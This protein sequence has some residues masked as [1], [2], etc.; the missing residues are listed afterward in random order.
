[1]ATRSSLKHY[2]VPAKPLRRLDAA[3]TTAVVVV[4]L[5]AV[6][7]VLAATVLPID[8]FLTQRGLGARTADAIAALFVIGLPLTWLALDGAAHGATYGMR[9]RRLCFLTTGSEPASFRRCFARIILGIVLLPLLPAS[10]IW[11]L[12]HA[13]HRS[14]AD[15]LCG[16]LVVAE[17]PGRQARAGQ[18]RRGDSQ[19][20]V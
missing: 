6:L 18:I 15:L 3:V 2:H 7:S 12:F 13:S 9:Q 4:V 16:I 17:P 8:V 14:L 1:M 11:A 20:I 10:A 5:S 19:G